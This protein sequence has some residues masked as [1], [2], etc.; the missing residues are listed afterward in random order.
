M[1]TIQLIRG[2]ITGLLIIT[3][4]ASI[5]L[6]GP[7][8]A[9][10][11]SADVETGDRARSHWQYLMSGWRVEREKLKSYEVKV[12]GVEQK[13]PG[14]SKA[15]EL[16][17]KPET[18]NISLR[19]LASDIG[20]LMRSEIEWGKDD[21]GSGT[22]VATADYVGGFAK[23]NNPIV[24]L[25]R[26]EGERRRFAIKL[27]PGMAGLFAVADFKYHGIVD[28][29]EFA[30]DI[31]L[32]RSSVYELKKVGPS[33][34]QALI[35]VEASSGGQKYYNMHRIVLNEGR[36]FTIESRNTYP[37][38]KPDDVSH[39]VDVILR[40]TWI[41]RDDVWLP[42]KVEDLQLNTRTRTDL[43]FDWI[44]VNRPL[45]EREFDLE[46]LGAPKGTMIVDER[47][48]RDKAIIVGHIGGAK[49]IPATRP[50]EMPVRTSTVLIASV[51]A[52]SALV[53]IVMLTVTWRRMHAAPP[54]QGGKR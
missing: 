30:Y 53:A 14:R 33:S 36:G 20:H 39:P 16:T 28:Q 25:S 47:L 21:P 42:A 4:L 23:T 49:E 35:G 52:V 6:Q 1:G 37:A 51:G 38:E 54:R 13:F 7:R 32:N 11:Q 10:A 2:T 9:H 45:P 15:M 5:G 40:A 29:I 3:T 27:Q 22:W 17:G 34:Y 31:F 26:P 46:D 19:L 50:S 12:K 24:I 18:V 41:N 43:A 8:P 44:S 48:D